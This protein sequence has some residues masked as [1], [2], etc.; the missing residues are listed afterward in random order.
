MYAGENRE[1]NRATAPTPAAPN[2]AAHARAHSNESASTSDFAANGTPFTPTVPV[3][4]DTR[5]ALLQAIG[6]A[7]Q[8]QFA[9]M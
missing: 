6:L 7:D 5:A 8:A 4:T 9:E 2:P 3:T 1:P